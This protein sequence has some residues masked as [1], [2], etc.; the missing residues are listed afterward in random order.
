MSQPLNG[1]ELALRD[2]EELEPREP[3]TRGCQDRHKHEAAPRYVQGADARSL[4]SPSTLCAAPSRDLATAR[5]AIVADAG[6]GRAADPPRAAPDFVSKF[7]RCSKESQ[8]AR[9]LSYK[10]MPKGRSG[11]WQAVFGAA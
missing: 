5:A 8:Q 6:N 10:V 9:I 4:G 2:V 7:L 3:L 11:V 1:S